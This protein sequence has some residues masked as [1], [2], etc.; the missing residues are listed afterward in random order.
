[1]DAL[2]ELTENNGELLERFE[3]KLSYRFR[4]RRLLQ[5]A[6]LHRSFSFEQLRQLPADNERLEF[7][8]DAVLD[9]VIGHALFVRYPEM[10]EGEMTRLRALLVNESNLAEMAA[11]LGLGGF[12]CLGKGEE[13]SRGRE[14]P[15]IL[16]STYEAVLGAVFLDGGYEGVAAFIDRHFQPGLDEMRR[17]LQ[18]ADAKSRLQEIL[19]DS[20]SEAPTYVLENTEGP[21]HQKIFT[22]SVRFRGLVLARGEALNKKVAE[23]NAAAEALRR[24]PELGLLDG[25]FTI[26]CVR[27][28]S[29]PF[30]FPISVAR[31]VAISATRRRLPAGRAAKFPAPP[32]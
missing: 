11:C 16:S 24:L 8:G 19:Q 28:W 13:S 26:R 31:N 6:L 10:R 25:R 14:K 30:S 22:V 15:S 32:R 20:Y 9:L 27:P 21:D 2:T 4:D 7:L 5:L 23:Q 12:L 1:V 3:E 29:S 18:Q 17:K